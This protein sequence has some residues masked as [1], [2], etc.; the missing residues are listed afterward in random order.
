M[1]KSKSDNSNTNLTASIIKKQL[2]GFDKSFKTFE[3][4]FD[5]IVNWL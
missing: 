2:K 4:R 3:K 5:A 1:E